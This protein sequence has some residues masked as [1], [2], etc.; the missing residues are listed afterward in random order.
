M[1]IDTTIIKNKTE[2]KS[3]RIINSPAGL[4]LKHNSKLT[5]LK[6]R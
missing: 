2:E 6:E 1:V 4:S 5:P 3:R